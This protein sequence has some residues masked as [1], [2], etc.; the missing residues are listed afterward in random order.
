MHL[1]E[2]QILGIVEADAAHNEFCHK[3]NIGDFLSARPGRLFQK[4]NLPATH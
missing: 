4:S 3:L 2:P 1:P